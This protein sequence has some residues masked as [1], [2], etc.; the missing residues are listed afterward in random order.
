MKYIRKQVF[1]LNGSPEPSEADEKKHVGIKE[2]DD[3]VQNIWHKR[4][5]SCSK[6]NIPKR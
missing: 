5:A 1:F 4:E 3:N 6:S 2:D